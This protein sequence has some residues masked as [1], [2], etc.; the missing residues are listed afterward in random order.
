MCWANISQPPHGQ[1]FGVSTVALLA[2][3]VGAVGWA[4]EQAGGQACHQRQSCAPDRRDPADARVQRGAGNVRHQ[5]VRVY[6][7]LVSQRISGLQGLDPLA[8]PLPN[9]TEVTT[10]T[11]ARVA[12]KRVPAGCAGRVVATLGGLVEVFL[13]GVGTVTLQ[14][15]QVIPRKEGLLRFA[16]RRAAA[17]DA[18]RPCVVLEAVVGSRAWGLADQGSDT[19]HRGVMVLPL[20]WQAS[21]SAAPEELVSLDGSSTYWTVQKVVTQALRADPNT[22]EMLFVPDVR[23]L[24]DMGQWILDAREAFVSQAIHGS[25]A[26]YAISQLRKLQ[27]SMRLARHRGLVLDWLRQEPRLD[28]DQ[29]AARLAAAT[30]TDVP[31]P[32]AAMVQARTYIKQ[33][34]RSLHDQ[35]LLPSSE[36]AALRRFAQTDADGLE[37]PRELR[38]KNA[39]NL[40]RLILT[41][42]GWLR[43]GQPSLVVA[44]A[45]R[46]RLLAIK[47]GQVDLHDV[48]ADAEALTRDLEDARVHSP[49]PPKPDVAAADRLLRRVAQEVARR[50]TA[51]V[52]GPFGKDAA[53]PPLAAW[54]EDK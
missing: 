18:L 47:R 7:C 15:S 45:H 24:D 54:E 35:G 46:E 44:G 21:L 2:R 17:W 36:F 12:D 31:D 33:L 48:L 13:V 34:C 39:Y 4:V 28:L 23:A 11:E 37:L 43:T 26:R 50:H 16:Q 25:F 1:A 49:L 10:R 38:P 30:L 27:Q 51:A 22:L 29:T 52:P 42:I 41:A 8:V 53:E 40:L 32:D 14:R 6:G 20:M 9:G 5:C 3:A 19:D